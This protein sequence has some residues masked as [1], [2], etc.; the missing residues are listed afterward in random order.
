MSADYQRGYNRGKASRQATIDELHAALT[1]MQERAERAEHALGLGRCDECHFWQRERS[2]HWGYC[3][4]TETVIGIDW[5]WRGEPDQKIATKQNFGC[6]RFRPTERVS[7]HAPPT[8]AL[9]A[10]YEMGKAH[11]AISGGPELPATPP[12]DH[13]LGG[14]KE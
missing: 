12:S 8:S 9:R 13:S 7:K 14:H 4:L 3:T 1:Q 2:C 10:L 6:I 5:P 11:L